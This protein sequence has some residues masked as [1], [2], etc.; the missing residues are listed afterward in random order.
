MKPKLS[1]SIAPGRPVARPLGLA[2]SDGGFELL[3][4]VYDDLL[5]DF[6]DVRTLVLSEPTK[7]ALYTGNVSVVVLKE[8]D[9]AK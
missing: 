7:V 5:E 8:L 9:V 1:K 4:K 6:L 3:L 2:R